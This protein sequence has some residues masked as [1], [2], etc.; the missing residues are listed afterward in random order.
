ME[1][2]AFFWIAFAI[3]VGVAANTR[4]RN[5][6]G[7]FI[8]ALAISP[9]I[10]GLLVLALP[11]PHKEEITVLQQRDPV[12]GAILG[13][14][15]VTPELLDLIAQRSTQNLRPLD[16][17]ALLRDGKRVYTENSYFV[18][19]DLPPAGAA[20]AYPAESALSQSQPVF[21]PEGVLKG[22]PYRRPEDGTVDA[23]MTGGL[24][25]FRDM[26]Q[27]RAA[28]EGRDE[29]PLKEKVQ[30]K[31]VQVKAPFDPNN[32]IFNPFGVFS[33]VEHHFGR[34][35]AFL[36]DGSVFGDTDSE[37][38]KFNSFEEWRRFIGE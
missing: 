11:R 26:E 3:I 6:G 10:A 15:K 32:P 13:H 9:L 4:G 34:R 35:V 1:T 25:R 33:K 19:D 14:R 31:D 37:P 38:R 2:I 7:W 27:F 5:G 23:M 36:S 12:S 22:L 18:R 29:A 8:L 28:A 20:D 21:K 16:V 24:A 30:V 17:A